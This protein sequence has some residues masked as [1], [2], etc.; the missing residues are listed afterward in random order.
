MSREWNYEEAFT[1]C[2][3]MGSGLDAR[4]AA[5]EWIKETYG[6]NVTDSN[7]SELL[8]KVFGRIFPRKLTRGEV[9]DSAGIVMRTTQGDD[10]VAEPPVGRV[11][12]YIGG[13]T[14]S[15]VKELRAERQQQQVPSYPLKS[16]LV[17]PPRSAAPSVKRYV[18]RDVSPPAKR[19]SF[20]L[21][22]ALFIRFRDDDG[23]DRTPHEET[24]HPE[25][26]R[27]D[28]YICGPAGGKLL[29]PLSM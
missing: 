13:A 1:H 6:P 10:E 19:V 11:P 23:D 17:W 24:E 18:Y 4:K 9:L 22:R 21:G 5:R 3:L 12:H 28:G 15:V 27:A 26:T 7:R 20:D 16:C 25:D 8:A 14:K 2:K 29:Y